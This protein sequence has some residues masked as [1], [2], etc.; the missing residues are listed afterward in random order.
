MLIRNPH[1]FNRHIF[2]TLKNLVSNAMFVKPITPSPIAS[3]TASLIRYISLEITPGQFLAML[4][5]QLK[6]ASVSSLKSLLELL[7]LAVT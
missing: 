7:E 6:D 2:L 3:L 1:N 5:S 4:K